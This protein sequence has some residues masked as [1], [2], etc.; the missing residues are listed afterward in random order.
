MGFRVAGRGERGHI[1]AGF[2]GTERELSVS[3]AICEV[4]SPPSGL[5]EKLGG[6]QGKASVGLGPCSQGNQGPWE[7]KL[8]QGR[9]GVR[10]G[11]REVSLR[12][13]YGAKRGD[14]LIGSRVCP[15][16]HPNQ[17]VLS[18]NPGQ[19][20][21]RLPPATELIPTHW[22]CAHAQDKPMSISTWPV[23]T[24]VDHPSWYHSPKVSGI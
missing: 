12:R 10:S 22:L 3:L 24:K 6:A 17:V 9:M 7:A 14:S 4:S 5:L 15:T 8:L 21:L 20:G 18:A 16:P 2:T 19:E 1:P 13:G 11:I 23:V